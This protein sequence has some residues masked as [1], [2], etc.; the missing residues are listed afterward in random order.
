MHD[1]WFKLVVVLLLFGLL[2][3][4]GLNEPDEGRYAEIGREMAE[5]GDWLV[6]NIWYVPHLDKPPMAYWLVGLS[7]AGFGL[8]EWAIRLPIA[9]S[10]LSGAIA[11]YLLALSI[12][13]RRVAKWSV[14]ILCSSILYWAIARM[15]MTDMILVQFSCWAIYCFWRAW[16]AIDPIADQ[17]TKGTIEVAAEK[18]DE[19]PEEAKRANCGRNSFLWHVGAWLMMAGGFL[20]KGPLV[21]LIVGFAVL[22][23]IIFRR[24]DSVRRSFVIMGTIGGLAVFA[25]VALP[26]YLILFERVAHSFDYM[27]KGQ[28]VG[29]ALEAAKKNR[30]GPIV[31]FIPIL[32]FG[33]IPWTMLLGWMWRKAHWGTLDPRTKDAWV[34]LTGWALLI[35]V[36]FSINSAKLP[37][38]IVP[39]MPAL[40]LLVALRWPDWKDPDGTPPLPDWVKRSVV[41]SPFVAMLA[42]PFVHRFAFK[43]ADQPW[44]WVQAGV[45]LIAIVVVSVKAKG[46]SF[47][48]LAALGFLVAGLNLAA[49]LIPLPL[50]DVHFRSNQTLKPL[51]EALLR[52][53]KEG[54]AIVVYQRIPQGLPI[55]TWPLINAS[56]RPFFM[57][58]PQH[59]MPYHYPGNQERLA[60]YTIEDFDELKK[61][62]E[63]RRIL[64]I[65][66]R[67]SYRAVSEQMTNQ[68][69]EMIEEF[70]HWELFESLKK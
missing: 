12:A 45:A 42:I 6:P 54:D 64:F 26:W 40:A 61:L 19:T 44:I 50:V 67:G 59:R 60:P 36:F 10:G 20:T 4:R 15:V 28:V 1:R 29:H 18:E 35:F 58:L 8:N 52:E 13:G 17:F 16:R 27:V 7:I 68:P 66:W 23:L 25:V 21:F 32:L 30:S 33:F 14:L 31:Y 34:M 22:P 49:L 3:T 24:G 70:G 56:A 37:H 38:Y 63:N 41:I 51:G 53:H 65:G 5:T 69:I 43:I 57:H 62:S 39:M 2:G 55:Y 46:M 47:Q 48:H 11:I 9:L